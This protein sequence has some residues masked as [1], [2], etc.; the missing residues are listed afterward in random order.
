VF[1]LTLKYIFIILT[2]LLFL[3]CNKQEVSDDKVVAQVGEKKLFQSEI[4]RIIPSEIEEQDSVLMANDYIRKWVKQE[5]L[6]NKANENLTLEQKNLTKEIE[7]YRNSLII[8]KYKNELMNQQMDTLVTNRQ[9]EQ[10]Y[11]ANTD[12]FKL[13]SNIVKAIFIKIPKEVANPK[14]IKE[15]ADDNSAEG[16]NALREYCIQYAKSFDFFNNNWVDFE[17]VKKNMPGEITDESQ[18]LARNNQIELN[19]SIYY[20]LVSIQDY[21]LKNELAPVE[22]VETNIKNLILN[23]RKI[24]FLKQIEENIYKEGIRQNKFKIYTEK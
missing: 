16:I 11:N 8:Y 9:I 2:G 14:L 1:R 17:L 7:E 23:K 4:S 12:N 15:L 19:D 5:L 10:Y 3:K 18:F 21:K 22:Y 24:E 6:I 20:Y 13:N